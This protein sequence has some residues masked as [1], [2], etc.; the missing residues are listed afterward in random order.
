M[1]ILLIIPILLPI[2]AGI[3]MLKRNFSQRAARERYVGAAVI[4]NAILVILLSLAVRE[5]EL[6]LFT[7]VKD[8]PFALRIDSLGAMF[9]VLVSLLWI[10]CIFYAFEY[11]THE[12]GENRFFAFYTM[13]F[14]VMMGICFSANLITLYLFYELLTLI[15]VPLV[16]HNENQQSKTAAKIYLTFSLTGAAMGLMAIAILV[17]LGGGS[18][19]VPGGMLSGVAAGAGLLQVAFVL[20]FFGF[21]VK[22]AILPFHGW[23]PCASVAPTPVSAL[24]HAVAVV[25]A[26]VFAVARVTY[27][28]IGADL[29]RGTTAQTIVMAACI[30]TILYGSYT[31]FRTQHLKRRLAYSTVSQLSYILL[32][33]AML[34]PE[35]YLGGVVH[36]VGHAV[37]KIT[38]FLCAG[39][40]I[41]KS[42]RE[43]VWELKGI[44]RAMPV[45][46]T[47]FTLAS[48]ALVGI[49]PL[50]GFFSKWYLG[51]AG[52][53][54]GGVLACLGL[55]VLG[56]S[57]LL[58][59]VYLLSICV[60]AFFPGRDFQPDKAD[61]KISDPNRYMT[62]PLVILAV[63][64][65]AFG[66]F[67]GPITRFVAL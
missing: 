41:Y 2:L 8:N 56:V 6:T 3:Y 33:L 4:G 16:I 47:V 45:T 13:A 19:F 60:N 43:Y 48:L 24:L 30:L 25:K 64:I 37:V 39:A 40:I 5:Q 15:T 1:S 59:A 9:A 38:L 61:K 28:T 36:I 53:K 63:A 14:G 42:H 44:G 29:L 67:I 54:D 12:G 34:S 17:F 65:L 58:T 10:L 11:M 22:S 66:I 7:L 57:A 50:P 27:F 62:V 52:A 20:A 31:A 26:G 55:A 21:G 18:T 35:G 46:M 51:L 49:P 32:G 23:L